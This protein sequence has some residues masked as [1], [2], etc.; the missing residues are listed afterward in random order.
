VEF[1]SAKLNIWKLDVSRLRKARQCA[2]RFDWSIILP[3]WEALLTEI[4]VKERH[5][6]LR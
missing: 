2:E 5:D 1:D 4:I 6:R 3:Q